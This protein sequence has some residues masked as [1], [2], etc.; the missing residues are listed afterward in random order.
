MRQSGELF[1]KNLSTPLP[2]RQMPA[3]LPNGYNTA[4]IDS[5]EV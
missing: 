2:T 3:G 1:K 4:T 5:L